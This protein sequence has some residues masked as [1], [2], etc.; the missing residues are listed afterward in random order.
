MK[1]FYGIGV[2]PGDKEL[3]T[4][5]AYNTIKNCDYI[6]IPKSKGESLAG[7]IVEDYIED[8][9]VIELEFPMGENNSIRYIKAAEIID[10]TLNAGESAV[11]L[12]LGDPMTYSTYIYLMMELN[13]R[14]IE[15]STVPGITSYGA[16]ASSLNIPL[17]LKGE[18]F[19]LCDG[20]IDD[21]ILKRI[22]SICILKVNRN[23]EEILNKL[24][25]QKFKYVYIRRCTQSEEK[26]LYKK[27]DILMDDD[28][29]SLII[30]R[31]GVLND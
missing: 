1:K 24:E 21:E 5:K 7:R 10:E 27:E 18:S 2:G 14:E 23:R 11:F 22:D 3:I 4:L 8:K 16:A 9:K 20:S 19:Y 13:T 6:F 26:I 31:R 28:Y 30:A 12:T 25:N 15:V 17:T 29:M